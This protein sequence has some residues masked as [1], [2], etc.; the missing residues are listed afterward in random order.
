[1]Q[2]L[3]CCF[4]GHR[5]IPKHEEEGLNKALHTVV[6]SLVAKGFVD[7]FVGG[8][9]GFDTMAGKV[10]LSQKALHP[11]IKLHILCA[12][13]YKST[14]AKH[15]WH[16]QTIL[17]KADSVTAVSTHFYAGCYHKRNRLLVDACSVCVAYKTKN[18][19]G[20]AYTV[21]YAE[22]QNKTLICLAK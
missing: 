18:H 8:A 4:T 19:G 2:K 13:P 6:V 15:A 7:F 3:A 10:V 22:K 12:I 16:P 20:T 5:E 11:E 17:D 21:A 14:V 1:M 9:S